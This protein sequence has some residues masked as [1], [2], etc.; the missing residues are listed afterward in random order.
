MKS[1]VCTLKIM[2]VLQDTETVK[3]NPC[4]QRIDN[5]TKKKKSLVA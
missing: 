4:L 3:N 1:W 2:S 5:L